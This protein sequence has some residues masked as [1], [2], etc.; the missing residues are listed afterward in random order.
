MATGQS[1]VVKLK[2]EAMALF[3]K[4]ETLAAVFNKVSLGLFMYKRKPTDKFKVAYHCPKCDYETETEMDLKM[5][6]E[7]NCEKC[8]N[9][10]FEQKKVPGQRGRKKKP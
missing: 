6:Y 5:P 8:G 3:N 7:V 2:E 4:G 10:I 1:L 9:L